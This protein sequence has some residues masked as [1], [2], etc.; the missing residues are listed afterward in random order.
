MVS[1]GV[2]DRALT[3]GYKSSSEIG[4]TLSIRGRPRKGFASRERRVAWRDHRVT[5][6][7]HRVNTISS[8]PCSSLTTVCAVI[9]VLPAD[10]N[11]DRAVA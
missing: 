2:V 8:L 4:L 9:T 6:R 3:C 1:K 10:S 11:F 5:S 7:E